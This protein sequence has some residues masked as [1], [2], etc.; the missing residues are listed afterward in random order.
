MPPDC[1]YIPVINPEQC[2]RCGT[3]AKACIYGALTFDEKEQEIRIQEDRCWSCGFCVGMCP[4]G[5][6]ELRERSHR[7]RL[8]WDNHG[9]AEPFIEA[10]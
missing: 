8:I 6:I 2:T 10:L 1:P 3:C 4:A 5:A 7:K 9:I